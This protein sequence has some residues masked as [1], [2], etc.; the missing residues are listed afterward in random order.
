MT[1]D[2]DRKL[3]LQIAR[4]AIV[5]HV[6]GSPAPA[7]PDEP[8]TRRLG[9]AFVT[10]HTNRA[11]RGCIG[12]IEADEPLG[13]VIARCA[14]AACARDPRFPPLTVNDL[15]VFSVELSL[16]GVPEA[17]DRDGPIEIGRHG[18]IVE[19]GWRRGL[20]LPQVAS[21][22]GWDRVVFLEQTCVKAGIARDAWRSG[23]LIWRFEAEIFAEADR[24]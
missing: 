13:D 8:V 6:S 7:P 20:L 15:E 1:G 3:L 24:D 9:G 11:L 12:H 14:V 16:L 17:I 22:R 23:V 5:S 4:V 10:L 19:S 18:L 21:E 2:D